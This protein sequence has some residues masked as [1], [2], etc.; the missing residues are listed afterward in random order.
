M[1]DGR[2]AEAHREYR[3]RDDADE[4]GA[5]DI[6]CHERTRQHEA[7]EREQRL[8]I[9]H[10]AEAD[11]R[12]LVRHDEARA[13]EAD[14]RDEQADADA[15]GDAQVLRHGIDDGLADMA[16]RQNQEQDAGEEDGAEC[17]RPVQAELAADIVGE[18]RVEAHAR[19]QSDR[20]VCDNAHDHRRERGNP[21][22]RGDGRLFRDAGF[23]EDV[24]IDK[25]DVGQRDERRD[26]SEDFRPDGRSL[27]AD[28]EVTLDSA[29]LRVFLHEDKTSFFHFMENV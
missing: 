16:D 3:R 15:D 12:R 7:E 14:E 18:E 10:M 25:D 9:R 19:R 4:D 23:R 24:R 2:I 6:A 8:R 27:L 5:L 20:V 29:C 11:E 17:D 22:R 26:A 28:L 1:W 21:D 13:L